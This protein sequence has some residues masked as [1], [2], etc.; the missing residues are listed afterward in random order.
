MKKAK[1][2]T[3]RARRA[4]GLQRGAQV[5]RCFELRLNDEIRPASLPGKVRTRRANFG[6]LRLTRS[7]ADNYE[8]AAAKNAADYKSGSR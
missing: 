2:G 7:G 4:H 5:R 8:F 1:L 3:R 6:P